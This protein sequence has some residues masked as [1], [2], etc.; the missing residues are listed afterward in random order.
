MDPAEQVECGV[1]VPAEVPL[2]DRFVVR[3]TTGTLVKHGMDPQERALMAGERPGAHDWGL[4]ADPVLVYRGGVEAER[5]LPPPGHYGHFYAQ[6]RDAIR[7]GAPPPVTP[8]RA[9]EVMAVTMAGFAS[10]ASAAMV[11]VQR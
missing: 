10:A 8:A 11:P 6:V 9:L 5:R 4:D 7:E 1:E 2:V 3:G